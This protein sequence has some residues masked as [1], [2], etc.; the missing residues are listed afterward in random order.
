MEHQGVPKFLEKLKK[1]DLELFEA[2]HGMLKKVMTPGVLDVKTKIL[3]AIAVDA[4]KGAKA[5]VENLSKQ[6]RRMGITDAEIHEALTVA[7][8]SANL[9]FMANAG[10]AFED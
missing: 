1:R 10:K 8:A 5:G 3:I 2:V 9:E 6:A 7:Q 4:G